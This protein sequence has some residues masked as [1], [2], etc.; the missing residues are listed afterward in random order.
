LPI[1][2]SSFFSAFFRLA[3]FLWMTSM[4][5]SLKSCSRRFYITTVVCWRH[6]KDLE[7]LHDASIHGSLYTKAKSNLLWHLV[8]AEHLWATTPPGRW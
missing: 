3:K 5:S 2:L 7:L 8:K 6:V 1:A 4:T